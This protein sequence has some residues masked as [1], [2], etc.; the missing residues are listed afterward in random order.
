MPFTPKAWKNAPD[1]STPINDVGLND[2][3]TRIKS[4]LDE[5]ANTAH[6]HAI[7]DTSGL[8]AA[9][10]AK[11]ATIIDTGWR[12][13]TTWTSAGVVTGLALPANIGPVAGQSGGIYVRRRDARVYWEFNGAQFSGLADF[14]NAGY[15]L[16]AAFYPSRP[17]MLAFTWRDGTTSTVTLTIQRLRLGIAGKQSDYPYGRVLEFITDAAPPT[18]PYPGTPA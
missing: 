12:A 8:Q 15:A 17:S 18:A 11:Q 2:L 5:K 10:D 6:T 3:E 13:V 9:L 16:G 14:Q 7:A 4:G 1:T